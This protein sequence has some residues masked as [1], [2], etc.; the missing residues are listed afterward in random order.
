MLIWFPD[1][2]NV[3]VGPVGQVE[4]SPLDLRAG[5]VLKEALVHLPT[6][7][8]TYYLFAADEEGVRKVAEFEDT[9][10]GRRLE[11]STSE[12]G[13]LFYTGYFTSNDCKE[14]MGINME[15]TGVLL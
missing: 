7:F 1:E 12:P 9:L 5:R 8:E 3:P 13:M 10:S 14:K 2:T 15:G 11:V 6:G 4:N